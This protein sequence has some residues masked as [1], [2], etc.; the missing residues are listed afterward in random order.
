MTPIV[1]ILFAGLAIGASAF[2]AATRR[3]VQAAFAL[4]VVLIAVAALFVQAGAGFLAAS[5]IIIYV[6]GI[7]ILLLFGVM[8]SG[9]AQLPAEA[10]DAGAPF[11][12]II[13]RVP[14]AVV[15]LAMLGVLLYAYAPVT[16][17][18]PAVPNS[19]DD[20]KTIGIQTLTQYLLPFEVIGILLLIALVGAAYVSRRNPPQPRNTQ[21]SN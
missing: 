14:A 20:V 18:P 8:L 13:N 11:T 3:L 5:Q 4:F 19:S 10:E 7:L 12:G 1:F 15:C 16:M 9:R 6:G 2:I 21:S 17:R